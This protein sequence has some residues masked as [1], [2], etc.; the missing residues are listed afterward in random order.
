MHPIVP[1]QEWRH[2]KDIQLADPDYN[3]PG[4]SDI[5]LGVE[6]FVEIICH[7]R[8]SGT[9]NSPTALETECGWVL[10][11]GAGNCV[12]P[13]TV[14]SYHVSM[15]TGDNILHQFWESE[16]KTVANSTLTLEECSVLDDF[17]SEHSRI[18]K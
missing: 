18:L 14:A 7:G 10:P 6:T 1:S 2:L 15:L 12:T 13:S 4:R 3:T 9:C 8:R 11:R 5:F 17:H 16:E